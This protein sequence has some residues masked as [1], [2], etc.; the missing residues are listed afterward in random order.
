MNYEFA[1]HKKE[2]QDKRKR[3]RAQA[4][5][6]RDAARIVASSKRVDAGRDLRAELLRRIRE[7]GHD[8]GADGSGSRQPT[9]ID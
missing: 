8:G 4:A 9:D 1:K 7:T 3:I 6:E 2:A 5:S